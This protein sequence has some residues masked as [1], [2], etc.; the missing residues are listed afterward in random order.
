MTKNVSSKEQ[1]ADR[2]RLKRKRLRDAAQV[3]AGAK[4]PPVPIPHKYPVK[5]ASLG[6]RQSVKPI[7]RESK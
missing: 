7:G 1:H 3:L 2:L 5:K 6:D 4:S